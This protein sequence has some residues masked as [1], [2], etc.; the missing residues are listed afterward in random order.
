MTLKPS[1]IVVDTTDAV[2]LASWWA[3]ALCAAVTE[4]NDGW[5]VVVEGAGLPLR[6]AFQ[7]VADPSPGKNRLHLDIEADDRAAEVA[8]LL[9]LGGSLVAEHTMGDFTWVVLA[10]PQGNQ[11][12][13]FERPERAAP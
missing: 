8:R 13:V 12:C 1:T 9:R 4:T 11:F 3:E 10:D 7:K 5:F 6:I 2:T